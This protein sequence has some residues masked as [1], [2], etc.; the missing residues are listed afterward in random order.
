MLFKFHGRAPETN[1]NFW[2]L[3]FSGTL[4]LEFILT[5][6]FC[7][8]IANPVSNFWGFGFPFLMIMPGLTLI[9]PFWGLCAI[10][11]GSSQMLKTYSSMNATMML[12]N[13][14]LTVAMLVFL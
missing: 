8:H 12:T 14:P 11:C 4:A 13:L 5:F 10:L 7:L 3:M 6:I 1:L 9:A 2:F